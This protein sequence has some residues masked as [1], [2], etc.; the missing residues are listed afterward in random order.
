MSPAGPTPTT[1]TSVSRVRCGAVRH[2][3]P[4][5]CPLLPGRSPRPASTPAEVTRPRRRLRAERREACAGTHPRV[6]V[7]GFDVNG[8]GR[9]RWCWLSGSCCW[10]A[11][12][13]PG[14]PRDNRRLAHH[15]GCCCGDAALAGAAEPVGVTGL[16]QWIGERFPSAPQTR[17]TLCWPSWPRAASCS[18]ACGRR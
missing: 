15:A 6:V 9:W 2:R 10:S 11:C 16:A 14:S 1:I 17:S 3:L 5:Y 18:P 8:L 4:T 12:P 7:G 13:C